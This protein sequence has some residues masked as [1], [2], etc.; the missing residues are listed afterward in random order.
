MTK[1]A[2]QMYTLKEACKED[3]GKTLQFCAE[4]GFD[5]VEYHCVTPIA[6]EEFCDL[7]QKNRLT[8]CSSI[9]DLELMEQ[10]LDAVMDFNRFCGNQRIVMPYYYAHDEE[11]ITDCIC[12]LKPIAKTLKDQ[13]FKLYYHN[14]GHEMKVMNG[15]RIMDILLEELSE[16]SV[17]LELDCFWAWAGGVNP[18]EFAQAHKNWMDTIIHI[19]D[20]FNLDTCRAE[21]AACVPE[22]LKNGLM[23]GRNVPTAIGRGDVPVGDVMNVAKKIG[24]EWLILEDDFAFPTEYEDVLFSM[25]TMKNYR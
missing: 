24:L 19:K 21:Q 10:D 15:K 6:K 12:R 8:L 18:V 4:A 17:L 14:H 11:S 22:Q 3:Y 9:F 13:G 16:Y 25:K 1:L 23:G 2:V 20:G 5:G 7:L